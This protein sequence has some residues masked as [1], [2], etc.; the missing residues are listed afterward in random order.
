MQGNILLHV[1]LLFLL[2]KTSFPEFICQPATGNGV[3]SSVYKRYSGY[4]GCP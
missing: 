2:E 3:I 4:S 1:S